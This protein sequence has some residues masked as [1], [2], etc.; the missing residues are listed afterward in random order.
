MIVKI[1]H[2]FDQYKLQSTINALLLVYQV[3][4]IVIVYMKYILLH[5]ETQIKQKYE[6]SNR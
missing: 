1:V 2:I 5:N 6:S 4:I 3:T